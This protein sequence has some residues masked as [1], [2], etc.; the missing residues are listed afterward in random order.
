[1]ANQPQSDGP[2]QINLPARELT[3]GNQLQMLMSVAGFAWGTLQKPPSPFLF[4]TEEG[5]VPAPPAGPV[6]GKYDG[7]CKSAAESV[8]IKACDAIERILDDRTRWNADFQAR[9][10]NDYA[11]AM[12][13]NLEYV[14]AKR[15]AAVAEAS[16]HNLYNPKLARL[17][18]NY[19]AVLGDLSDPENC[20]L[21][22]GPS[23]AEALEAFD[24]AFTSQP[25]EYTK[26]WAEQ[27]I[28]EHQ[29]NQQQMDR[30]RSEQ[31]PE[32]PKRRRVY[33][34]DSKTDGTQPEVGGAGGS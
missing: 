17:G 11:N 5:L 24:Q 27:T 7:G 8:F 18:S 23:P 14:K 28:N 6:G 22:V 4:Q 1:M 9:I 26:Q 13:M 32:P 15:D 12:A 19:I 2:P 25:T 21:G 3:T 10:E 33:P 20:V 34:R 16:P 31:T 29:K 30:S